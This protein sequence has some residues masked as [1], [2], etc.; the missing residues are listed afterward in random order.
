MRYIFRKT[1]EFFDE[2]SYRIFPPTGPHITWI[3]AGKKCK[4][5]GPDWK[6]AQFNSRNDFYSEAC[7]IFPSPLYFSDFW[8]RTA[9]MKHAKM[10]DALRDPCLKGKFFWIQN[11]EGKGSI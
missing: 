6:L 5:L 1:T 2:G 3:T 7:F 9:E 4:S 8:N 11:F 10:Y